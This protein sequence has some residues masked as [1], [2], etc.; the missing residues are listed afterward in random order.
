MLGVQLSLPFC[1]CFL[2]PLKLLALT[3][4]LIKLIL[5][6]LHSGFLDSLVPAESFEL[7][8]FRDRPQVRLCF[9]E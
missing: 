9:P 4:K 8:S 1:Q 3:S 2:L 7:L 6:S 5:Q